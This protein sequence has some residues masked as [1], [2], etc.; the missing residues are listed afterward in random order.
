MAWINLLDCIYPIGSLYFSNSSTSPASKIGGTWTAISEAVIRGSSS[1]G[2]IGSDE[3]EIAITEMPAHVHKQSAT[4]GL[5]GQTGGNYNVFYDSTVGTDP[6]AAR[7]TYET[8]GGQLCRWFNVLTTALFG[9]EQRKTSPRG[10]IK[11]PLGFLCSTLFTSL[12]RFTSVL[13]Q[14]LHL[15]SLAA[16][17]Q[18]SKLEDLFARQVRIMQRSLQAVKHQLRLQKQ[19]CRLTNIILTLCQDIQFLGRDMRQ[20]V[21]GTIQI[22]RMCGIR[23]NITLQKLAVGMN[24]KIDRLTS[25]YIFGGALLKGGVA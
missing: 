25:P 1:I 8:G 14:H 2:Y 10:D 20:L 7:N 22:M 16:H 9:S 4:K 15:V 5:Y 6:S 17:G 24:T 21:L 19:K 11:W 18:L 23:I 12:E 3:H 13:H